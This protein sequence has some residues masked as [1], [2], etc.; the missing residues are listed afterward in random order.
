MPASRDVIK[1]IA[2]TLIKELGKDVAKRVVNSI[3][4]KV[5]EVNGSSSVAKTFIALYR[6]VK[7]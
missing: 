1:V 7:K 4:A 2:A 3:H 6:E 5:M